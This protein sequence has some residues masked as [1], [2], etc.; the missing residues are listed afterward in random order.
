MKMSTAQKITESFI[1]ND[2]ILAEDKDLY[3]YGLKQGVFILLNIFTIIG[4]G[5]ILGMLWQSFVLMLVYI[6]LRSYA[7]GYH[8][9]TPLK[10]YLFSIV[11]LW[12]ALLG[13]R[14]IP[15]TNFTSLMV[16]FCAGSIIFFLAPVEDSNKPLDEVEKKIYKKRSRILLI[17]S[18]GVE[19]LLW[20]IGFKK[21]AICIMMAIIMAAM[22][23]VMGFLRNRETILKNSR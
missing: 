8:A 21:A 4:M 3:I 18:I 15:W 7:G 12:V 19:L 2:I 5:L 16:S 6:P 23:V 20:I 14:L 10:C 1:H 11:M 22:M 13:I 9:K 17:V